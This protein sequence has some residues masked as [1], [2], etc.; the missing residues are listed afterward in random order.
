MKDTHSASELAEKMGVDEEMIDSG[1]SA[2]EYL[3]HAGGRQ[4]A[5]DGGD[6]KQS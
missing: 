5:T 3:D 2:A 4:L 6:S 1:D